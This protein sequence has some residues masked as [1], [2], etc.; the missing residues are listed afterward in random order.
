VA[1]TRFREYFPA[2]ITDREENLTRTTTI[3]T[4]AI[5]SSARPPA[6][7]IARVVPIFKW[8]ETLAGLDVTESRRRGGGLRVY[9]GDRWHASGDDERLA[10]VA[11]LTSGADPLHLARTAVDAGHVRPNGTTA[12]DVATE[13][14]AMRVHPYPVSYDATAKQWYCD[15]TFDVTGLYFPFVRLALARYQEHSL[16][17]LHLSPIV[18]AGIYQLASDRWVSLEHLEV[19]GQ[20]RVTIS[21]C[22]TDTAAFQPP[23]SANI[24]QAIEVS[25]EERRGAQLDPDLGWIASGAAH[26][27]V[28]DASPLPDDVLWRG[29]VVLPDASEDM[30]LRLFVREFEVFPPVAAVGGQRW[31]GDADGAPAR[32]LVYGDTIPL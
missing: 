23:A 8:N 17:N 4:I 5:R 13:V 15:V 10:V 24:G 28:V 2:H 22:G 9:L 29:T 19:A 26:Q 3:S 32:R 31:I 1:T 21:V 27:P 14:G 25:L 16:H 7:T 6:P 20:R 12:V 30:E 11:P 18:H